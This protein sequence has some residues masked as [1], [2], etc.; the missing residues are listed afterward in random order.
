MRRSSREP[1]AEG[2]YFLDTNLLV[3]RQFD[4][5]TDPK[6][7][8]ARALIDQ[9]LT[10]ALALRLSPQILREF[11]AVMTRSPKLPFSYSPAQALRAINAYLASPIQLVY[12]TQRTLQ[13]AL[14]MAV[15]KR[16]M[17]PRIH[18]LYIS[19]TMLDHEM[20]YIFTE[21]VGDFSGIPGITPINPFMAEPWKSTLRGSAAGGSE[22]NTVKTPRQG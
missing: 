15:R 16:I 2:P 22:Q 6:A 3:Y 8:M 9:G 13:R 1:A 4:P 19:A 17:G 7:E 20:R 11:Y 10:G 5:K 14:R 12:P 21:N 18:D